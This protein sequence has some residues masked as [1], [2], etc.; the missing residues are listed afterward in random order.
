MPFA[1]NGL[2]TQGGYVEEHNGAPIRMLKLAGTFGVLPLRGTA[3]TAKSLNLGQAIFA[4][5]IEQAQRVATSA[6]NLASDATG[7]NPNFKPN[8]V[9]ASIFD[10]PDDDSTNIAKTSGYYQMRLLEKFFEDYVAFKKTREGQPYRLALAAWKKQAVYLVTPVSFNPTQ[11]ADSPLEHRY[12]LQLRAYRRISLDGIRVD[13]SSQYQPAVNKPNKLQVMLKAILDARDIL[14]NARDIVA[15]VGGDLDHALFEPLRQVTMFLKDLIA[16]PL[17]FSDLP[18]QVLEN[19]QTAVIEYVSIKQAFGTND[20]FVDQSDR[21]VAA[22]KALAQLGVATSKVDTGVGVLRQSISY[23]TDAALEVFRHP[24]DHYDLFKDIQPGQINLPPAAVRSIVNE[25][26]KIQNLKR[27]DFEQMRDSVAQVAADFA[28]AVGAG[29]ATYNRTFQRASRIAPRPDAVRLPGHVRAQSRRHGAEPSGGLG[30]H[31]P[32]PVLVDYVA[33]LASQLGIAFTAPRSKFAVP[34]PYGVTLEQ[35]ATRYLGDPDRWIEIAT[36]NGLRAPYVDEVGFDLPLLTNGRGNEVNV[37]DSSNLYVG[38]QIWISAATTARTVRRIT[39]I[40]KLS[41]SNSI[42]TVDGDSDLERFSTLAS[43][44]L[45][46]FLPDTVNSQMMLYIPS[47][48]EPAGEDVQL[49]AIPGLDVYDQLLNVGGADLLLTSTGDLAI[50][51]DGDC[52]LAVGL[53]NIIQTA[54]TRLAV[55]QGTLN[56]HPTFG[57]PIKPGMSIADTDAKSLLKAVKNLFIDDPA[58]T[59]VMNASVRVQGPVTSIALGVG[60][61][62]QSQVVPI[63]LDIKR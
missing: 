9:D 7:S 52:R 12:T 13:P 61:R 23:A 31:R 28:D 55:T 35:L 3:R 62:G 32:P 16:V 47:D 50:T 10:S 36:L 43:A 18:V 22:Y 53:A 4:G 49:K 2:V 51:P 34:Y 26:E 29:N 11:A 45:H 59:G 39:K 41:A 8:L 48:A 54:R 44:S 27:F 63:T 6:K 57:L 60:V 24:E 21:V 37:A 17:A 30:R 15:A 19:C 38:Q 1:I 56:R 33:G 58:F 14:E 5:T 20:L 40:H 25:R 46:A 42:V